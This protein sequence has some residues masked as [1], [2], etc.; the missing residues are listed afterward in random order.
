MPAPASIA[1]NM[2]IVITS[3]RVLFRA[4]D[5][6]QCTL[7]ELFVVGSQKFCAYSL[8]VDT[9]SNAIGELSQTISVVTDF[10][11]RYSKI[12]SVYVLNDLSLGCEIATCSR[13]NS[14]PI[15]QSIALEPNATAR[16]SR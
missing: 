11:N 5:S 3:F 2:G 12:G 4:T 13:I 15:Q 8:K 9:S 14:G 16:A 6:T 10:H 1:N 7:R